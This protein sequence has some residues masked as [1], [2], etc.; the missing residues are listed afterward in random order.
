MAGISF[1]A[2]S[3]KLAQFPDQRVAVFNRHP[4]ITHEQIRLPGAKY[5]ESLRPWIRS[6][7]PSPPQPDRIAFIT[8]ANRLH[9]PPPESATLRDAGKIRLHAVAVVAILALLRNRCRSICSDWE[10]DSEGRAAILT[11]AGNFN[12]AVVKLDQMLNYRE[13]QP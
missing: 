11:F 5:F 13:T 10:I 9:H 7:S 6:I 2:L 8:H 3:R 12:L 4:D 1:A